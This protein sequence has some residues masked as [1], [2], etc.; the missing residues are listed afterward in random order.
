MIEKI[1]TADRIVAFYGHEAPDDRGRTL[2]DIWTWD[3]EGLE[4]VHDYIQWLF[5]LRERSMVNFTAPLVTDETVA[6]FAADAA[7]RDNLARSFELMLDFYGL[8]I[9]KRDRGLP[10]APMASFASRGRGWLTPGNHNHLRVTR[11]LTSLRLLGLAPC[12]AALFE[13][14]AM[15]YEEHPGAISPVTFDYW[16]RAART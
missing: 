5:P 3:H 15:I 8:A 2:R 4:G 6:R 10:I 13:R 11:I 9:D 7:L 16:Q 1:M 14:L 12:A